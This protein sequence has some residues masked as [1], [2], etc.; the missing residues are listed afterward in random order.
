VTAHKSTADDSR[1]RQSL[2]HLTGSNLALVILLIVTITSFYG[3]A[4]TTAWARIAA[5]ETIEAYGFAVHE[6]LMYNFSSTG[7]FFQTIHLGYDDSWAWS[8][9]RSITFPINSIIYGTRPSPFWLSQIQAFW[10][11]LGAIPAA[12]FGYSFIR[13]KYAA[14]FG[15]LV[16][17]TSPALMALTLQDYQDLVYATPALMFTIAAM[18]SG[19][20]TLVVLG[21]A[22]GA[23][24]REETLIISLAVS[25]FIWPGTWRQL[26]RNVVTSAVTL[27][28]IYLT[29][30][31]TSPIQNTSHDMPLVNAVSGFLSWPPNIF[32]PGFPYLG[33]FYSL[34]WAPLGIFAI[35]APRTALLGVALVFMHTTVP[36]GHGVDRSWGGHVHHMAPA[37]PFF[38]AATIQGFLLVFSK[39]RSENW[40]MDRI[41]LERSNGF[42][43]LRFGSLA[44]LCITSTLWTGNWYKNWSNEYNLIP[45]LTIQ[46]PTYVHPVWSLTGQLEDSDVP[47]IDS[48]LSLSVSARR[49]SYTWDDSL[50][51][52]AP[53]LG[54]GAGT[55]LIADRREEQLIEWG[56]A[57][58]GAEVLGE[59]GPYLLIGWDEE[60]VDRAIPISPPSQTHGL[61]AWPGMPNGREAIA[62]VA[63]REEA[64][65]PPVAP[66]E[67][68]EHSGPGYAPEQGAR[69]D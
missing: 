16:Y 50:F 13:S 27:L 67:T 21:V 63:P 51:E 49:A 44:V 40:I 26:R 32:T 56:M 34:L 41:K 17:L 25:A 46:N 61:R 45:S 19:R 43:Y 37:L 5:L 14:V 11:T 38:M 39:I 68:T 36:W 58:A 30:Q 6:Q 1:T 52:K 20:L 60:A 29:L 15:A 8:G 59:S 66:F 42:N 2:K 57:M 22:I 28:A 18:R 53:G 47:I 3:T 62:G 33:S 12:W 7:G 69:R 64:P 23:M 54:L 24:P 48:R 9:H 35:F 4:V 10:M 55:H 65:A 31:F